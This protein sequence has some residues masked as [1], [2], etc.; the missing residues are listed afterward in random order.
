MKDRKGLR[1]LK[2][3]FHLH[4]PA[5]KCFEGICTAEE[6][7]AKVKEKKID[8]IAITD[9]NNAEWVDR[10]KE[11]AEKNNVI[12]FPGVEITCGE[13][14]I[15]C[16]VLFDI[17]KT[18]QD[19]EDFL[20]NLG[21]SRDDFAV[22]GAYINKTIEELLNEV[23]KINGLLI[24]AHIDTY[25]GLNKISNEK[26]RNSFLSDEFINGVQIV[27][28][29][30]NTKVNLNKDNY[31]S[32][33][34]TEDNRDF[35]KIA[36]TINQVNN[37][38]LSKLTF[39]DN[40]K[41][42]NDSKHGL[43]GIGNQYTWIKMKEKPDLESLRQALI[44]REY[45]VKNIF[46]SKEL[47][48]RTPNIWIEKIEIFNTELNND[49]IVANFN[50][51]MTNIIGGRGTGKSSILSVI[52][53]GLNQKPVLEGIK[54][55]FDDFYRKNN[56][57]LGKG[58]FKEESKINIY[59]GFNNERYKVEKTFN[60]VEELKLFKYY[61]NSYILEENLDIFSFFNIEAYSQKEIYE[62]ANKSN[63]LL[64]V[65]D[66]SIEDISH[67]KKGIQILKSDYRQLY[68]EIERIKK[69]EETLSLLKTVIELEENK[70]KK[71]NSE[72]Y[73]ILL[74][75]K[76]KY[77]KENK[78]IEKLKGGY[79]KIEEIIPNNFGEIEVEKG[80]EEF[81]KLNSGIIEEIESIEQELVNFK[82]KVRLQKANYLK[83][84]EESEW[85][86][87]HDTLKNQLRKEEEK[88]SEEIGT[89]D[90]KSINEKI[91]L[92]KEEYSQSKEQ[93][94]NKENL[95]KE[96]RNYLKL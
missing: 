57:K 56:K 40:P 24:P 26:S 22:E 78:I 76:E 84:I 89:L 63:Y 17:N 7:V 88:I 91:K 13:S 25:K 50:P 51:Q 31:C 60:T 71:I 67:E 9:H 59:I 48:Y 4:T 45:R 10:I 21:M 49:V 66:S 61:G 83:K 73:T 87:K 47:P 79:S 75:E 44:M 94:K 35:T 6:Y 29:I 69:I 62:L 37:N 34:T 33:K 52:R 36:N 2:C 16:L 53:G 11:E 65:I 85:K 43:W 96:K 32:I 39:S 81:K 70:L 42:E 20:I 77:E 95:I 41:S 80:S 86:S 3:D 55:E 74:D 5:S 68:L 82:E 46:D 72:D 92:K 58:I 15:H 19:I 12:V 14:E 54:K 64:E 93:I 30:S 27:N 90:L 18:K 38:N 23:K 1:W 8:V 28:Q